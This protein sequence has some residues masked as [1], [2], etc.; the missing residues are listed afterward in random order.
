MFFKLTPARNDEWSEEV[1]HSFNSNTRD[2][3]EPTCGVVFDALG[4]IYGATQFGGMLGQQGWG[5][6]FRLAPQA[7]GK[8][9][10]TVLRTFDRNKL[11]GGFPSGL[12]LDAKGNLYGSAGAGGKYNDGGVVFKL[13]PRAEG[14]WAETVLHFFGKGNDGLGPGGAL[15]FDSAGHLLGVTNIGGGA[16]GSCG[17]AGCGVVFEVI[18]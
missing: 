14:K 6:A 17:Q 16:G 3:D 7:G 13:T 5:T 15:I 1:L 11:E 8:W 2:G 12:I 4:N 18:Q 10:E 9:K